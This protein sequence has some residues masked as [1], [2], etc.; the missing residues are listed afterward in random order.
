MATHSSILAWKITWAESLAGYSP[1]GL[2]ESDTTEPAQ[3]PLTGDKEG[4]VLQ[5]AGEGATFKLN[6]IP[7]PA[8][9][10]KPLPTSS[11]LT[12]SL[13]LLQTGF[14]ALPLLIQSTLHTADNGDPG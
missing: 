8:G 4:R 6:P 11:A 2:N 1:Q 10:R 14:S 5:K 9:D 12:A 3:L 13:H 7:P